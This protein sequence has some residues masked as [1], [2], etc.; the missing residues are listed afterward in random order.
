MAETEGYY[1]APVA[2]L[3]CIEFGLPQCFDGAIRSEMAIFSHLIQRPAPRNMIQTLFL[4]K[5]DYDRYARMDW[6]PVFIAEVV[7]ALRGMAGGGDDATDRDGAAE[8]V[9]RKTGGVG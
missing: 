3:D 7:D 5:T 1:P 4:G 6:L 9:D 8:A 2:I